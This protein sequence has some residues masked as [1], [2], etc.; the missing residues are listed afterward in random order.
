[1]MRKTILAGIVTIAAAVGVGVFAG[2]ASSQQVT[3]YK[4]PT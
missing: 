2:Q 4:S 1:M 3:V